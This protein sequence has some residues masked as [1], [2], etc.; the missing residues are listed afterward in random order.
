MLLQCFKKGI[1]YLRDSGSK[2]A[3]Q[4]EWRIQMLEK[5]IQE[6]LFFA[7]NVFQDYEPPK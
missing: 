6:W 5:V 3:V 7:V 2:E 4:N 1:A